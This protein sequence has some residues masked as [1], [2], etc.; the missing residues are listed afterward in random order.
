MERTS[1]LL[2]GGG[3]FINTNLPLYI[4]GFKFPPFQNLTTIFFSAKPTTNLRTGGRSSSP[5]L[6]GFK[7]PQGKC[8]SATLAPTSRCNILV[9]CRLKI[10]PVWPSPSDEVV[11][12]V[13]DKRYVLGVCIVSRIH[14]LESFLHGIVLFVVWFE[15]RLLTQPEARF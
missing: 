9:R 7:N 2:G 12:A 11:G 15:C 3:G 8:I 1:D 14:L 6:F 5:T 13:H 4:N 10:S